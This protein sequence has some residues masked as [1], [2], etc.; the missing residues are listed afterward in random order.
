MSVLL[1]A[2]KKA[3]AEKKAKQEGKS[4]VE[5]DVDISNAAILADS[6]GFCSEAKAKAELE[7]RVLAFAEASTSQALA[8]PTK[9]DPNPESR[10]GGQGSFQADSSSVSA[11]PSPE[12]VTKASKPISTASKFK[13]A[14][15]EVASAPS[16]PSA[17][18]KIMDVLSDIPDLPGVAEKH[19][20]SVKTLNS[21]SEPSVPKMADQP[22]TNQGQN[23]SSKQSELE[24]LFKPGNQVSS[25]Q[26]ALQSKQVK[27]L[28]SPA[29]T[30]TLK[31]L[32]SS[33]TRK[34]YI[35]FMVI[36]AFVAVLIYFALFIFQDLE[37]KYDQ[38]LVQ[39]TSSI[40]KPIIPTQDKTQNVFE[41]V[42]ASP[43][44][45]VDIYNRLDDKQSKQVD[46]LNAEPQ[47]T[48]PN[49]TRSTAAP[50][51]RLSPQ[52]TTRPGANIELNRIEK[53]AENELAYQAYLRSDFD[54]AEIHYRRGLADNPN[55]KNSQIG[56]AAVAAQRQDYEQA[57]SF[58]YRVLQQHPEDVDALQGIASIAA[59]LGNQEATLNDLIGLA[60]RYPDS[61][62]LQFALGN[63]YAQ[64]QDWFKAQQHYFDS[65]RLEQNNPDYRLN[66]AV[67]LDH[68]GQLEQ[69]LEHY[70]HSLALA[71]N[72][73]S[74][75]FNSVAVY[76]RVK[77]LQ[78]FME[79]D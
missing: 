11:V 57:M 79:Q 23:A 2:L 70:K 52:Q 14:E 31:P 43:K 16:Y 26:R 24:A 69:A 41:N 58:Y 38:Q 55:S 27:K 1:D 33:I 20:Q 3:A 63:Q 64:R 62:T 10:T 7:A 30:T 72:D 18:S 32:K 76:Q 28:F 75:Q 29:L 51:E 12:P 73:S 39:F 47:T 19:G 56:L 40:E 25:A 68:L 74:A 66:L 34:I 77:L 54:K 60:R 15:S 78:T 37:R 49:R 35:Y 6:E 42:S 4:Q 5:K 59:E 65:V 71:G 48:Q 53:L 67:S 13:L 22:K 17:S 46:D 44:S 50:K 21:D 36:S 9:T 8:E 45:E 61:A